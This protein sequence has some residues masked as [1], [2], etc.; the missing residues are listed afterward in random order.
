MVNKR[1]EYLVFLL[2]MA[3]LNS[4]GDINFNESFLKVAGEI[5]G[6]FIMTLILAAIIYTLVTLPL[7]KWIVKRNYQT[8]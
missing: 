8:K 1:E 7:Y 4:G 5:F 2:T 6:Y 3:L